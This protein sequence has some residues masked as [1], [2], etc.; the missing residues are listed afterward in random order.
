MNNEKTL[1]SLALDLWEL[2]TDLGEGQPIT[3]DRFIAHFGRDKKRDTVVRKWERTLSY[4]RKSPFPAEFVKVPAEW[5][6]H[7]DG[8]RQLTTAM[9]LPRGTRAETTKILDARAGDYHND[10]DE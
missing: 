5:S 9:V 3:R 2:A 4:V 6:T 7:N 1:A 10:P 8:Q